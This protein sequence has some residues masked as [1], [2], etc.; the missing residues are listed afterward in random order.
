[1]AIRQTPKKTTEQ[2][3][4]R[5]KYKTAKQTTVKKFEFPQPGKLKDLSKLPQT[6]KYLIE[7]FC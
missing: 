4:A 3:S 7:F 6:T 5:P 2:I 1:M